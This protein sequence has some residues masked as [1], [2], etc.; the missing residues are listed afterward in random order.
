MHPPDLFVCMPET[1]RGVARA[2]AWI[3]S[4]RG[5]IAFRAVVAPD[6]RQ[7]ALLLVGEMAGRPTAVAIAVPAGPLVHGRSAERVG[8]PLIPTPKRRANF[9]ENDHDDDFE[10]SSRPPSAR[11]MRPAAR[12][13]HREAAAPDAPGS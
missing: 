13:G 3:T 9:P 5:S 11:R 2:Q 6:L 4:L 12:E 8:L 10:R 1:S 7:L